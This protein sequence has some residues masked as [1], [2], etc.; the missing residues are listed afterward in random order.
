MLLKRG[1]K[2]EAVRALQRALVAAGH[3]LEID[4]DFGRKTEDAVKEFQRRKGLTVDG[5]VGPNTLQALGMSLGGGTVST[6]AFTHRVRLHFRSLSLTDTPFDKLLASTELVY[7]QH[8]IKVEF[9]SGMSLGLSEAEAE[10]FKQVDGSCAWVI[11]SGEYRELQELGGSVPSNEI[12][13]YYVER[14]GQANLLGCGGHIPGQPA[15]IVASQASRWDT[16]HEI[17]H[18]LLTS[19]FSPVH[20][21][22]V[23]NLMF[24]F[25]S[26]S[27]VTPTL[28]AAQI[29]QMKT[30]PC[31]SAIP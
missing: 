4:G 14:F 6:P 1:S 23:K 5:V 24:Q 26:T 22:D 19:A 7:A 15:C 2:G 25:S 21:T 13:V 29:A 31:C 28:T 11:D 3:P 10:R 18:V 30:S 20:E 9:Q 12:L 8:G 27:D 17:G 16:A